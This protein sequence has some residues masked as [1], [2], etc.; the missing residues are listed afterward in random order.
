MKYPKTSFVLL[1][2][3]T[4]YTNVELSK[5]LHESTA[6]ITKWR[7]EGLKSCPERVIGKLANIITYG[8]KA[9]TKAF[10]KKAFLE[11]ELEKRLHRL[12]ESTKLKY[13]RERRNF[14]RGKRKP[15]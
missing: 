11:G 1:Q 10:K 3:I 5:H 2:K 4:G 9:K 6:S 8:G 15:Y 12:Y 7:K 14:H 13:E